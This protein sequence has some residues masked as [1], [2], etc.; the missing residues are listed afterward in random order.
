MSEARGTILLV[1]DEPEILTALTD[2]LEDDYDVLSTTSPAQALDMLR[3]GAAGEVSVIL[4]DQR[5]PGMTGDV[6]LERA[7][8]LTDAQAILLTGYA[9][10]EAVVG[11]VNRGRIAGYAA[12]PW[13]P[14]A[15]RG[16]VEGAHE[17]HRLARALETERTLLRGLL[18]N[19][20]DLL[21]F[22]DAEGR[23][24][25]LNEAKA[26]S[27]GTTAAAAL[28][29]R[30]A[31]FLPPTS[32]AQLTRAEELAA[33]APQ[34]SL[35]ERP[36]EDA[37]TRWFHVSR[38]PLRNGLLV[39]I[40]R[41]V[42]EA[43]KMEA[44]LRQADKMQALGTMAGGV[45]HDFN[46]LLTAI[47]GSLQLAGRRVGDN[48]ALIRLLR[49]A[50]L[51]AERGSA[52]TRRLLSFSRQHELAPRTVEVNGLIRG[53]GDLLARTLGG[54]VEVRR[55]LAPQ[56]WPAQVDPD[57]LELALLNLCINARDAMP[58]GGAITLGTRNATVAE[59]EVAELPAGDYLAVSVADQGTGMSPEVL[60]RVFEP[61]FTTKEVGKGTGLGLSMVYGLTRQSGGSITIESTPGEGTRV[62][63]YL[64]RA[65]DTETDETGE[66]P[67]MP[68]PQPASRVLVVDDEATVREVTAGF[69]SDLGH[70]TLEAADGDA[71]LR[72][73]ESDPSIALLVADFAMPR[74]NGAEL[75][76]RA[77]AMR[78]GLPILV[79]TGYAELAKLSADI[80]VLHKPYRQ[81]DLAEHVA[82][83]L[84]A[85]E[86][87]TDA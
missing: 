53:M 59:G 68:P 27:L 13:E 37:P 76:E 25:R 4:S 82:V 49:N 17:R 57:Q 45:A 71:A 63:L 46:N 47:L 5:M 10:L 85:E 33:Q 80:P 44:R 40:E 32:A 69:L 43:R 55:E 41:D 66:E 3:D 20:P 34:E 36:A 31:A 52:L 73:L 2:L 58:G 39:A 77:R 42:T 30:E 72:M 70:E 22:K 83:L 18:E 56:P 84:E 21:S 81:Q 48:P 11:A 7:R 51:A 79:V 64:P 15:L 9:E 16:M 61:F 50:T 35:E 8:A 60:A 87:R 23:F 54:T 29:R 12:K 65:T 19:T 62:T 67:A 78:P 26:R 86:A 1:D 74:M 75:S 28:G 38:I 24:I 14:T 6:F